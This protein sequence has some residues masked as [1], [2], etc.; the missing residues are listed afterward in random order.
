MWCK[1]LLSIEIALKWSLIGS[2]GSDNWEA[3]LKRDSIRR[4][5]YEITLNDFKQLKLG[6]NVEVSM[7][8]TWISLEN[9][10]GYR[11]MAQECVVVFWRKKLRN[12][13]IRGI[14]DSS[15]ILQDRIEIV[16]IWLKSAWKHFTALLSW[17]IEIKDKVI[18]K[19]AILIL[20][21]DIQWNVNNIIS[22][23]FNQNM[24]N[25]AH[26]YTHT[27]ELLIKD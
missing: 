16:F 26:L 8:S 18:P 5:N 11:V 17:L 14:F 27:T 20:V 21:F 15:N 25:N 2:L 24:Q 3:L 23:L 22:K 13:N 1:V 6:L 9:Y 7:S 4:S 10:I 12:K 19:Q